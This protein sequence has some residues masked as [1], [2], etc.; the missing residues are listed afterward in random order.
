[1]G[2]ALAGLWSMVPKWLLG[3]LLAG[4][5]VHS[6]S[7]GVQRD[8]A[9][10]DLGQVKVTLAKERADRSE[11]TTQ[12][13]LA[14]AAAESKNRKLEQA[15]VAQAQENDRALQKAKAFRDSAL[16]RERADHERMRGDIEAFLT[17]PGG[18]GAET[19]SAALELERGR[20]ATLGRLFQEADGLA[21]ELADAAER[22]ADEARALK[23]QLVND[24]QGH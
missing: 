2:T 4:A 7:V 17:A 22:H 8:K 15:L 14:A 19:C 13:A 10:N 18:G 16:A 3:V 5:L 12:R 20:S 11:E 6:C 21:G 23:R 1:M 9:R 24:R